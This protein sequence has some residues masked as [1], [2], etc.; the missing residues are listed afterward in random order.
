MALKLPTRIQP[1]PR[2]YNLNNCM[3][4]LHTLT[5]VTL[6]STK[7]E[8]RPLNKCPNKTPIFH[9]K[10][11]FKEKILKTNIH[12]RR[13]AKAT[14]FCFRNLRVHAL[15]RDRKAVSKPIVRSRQERKSDQRKAK[16]M[17]LGANSRLCSHCSSDCGASGRS[18]DEFKVSPK[19]SLCRRKK[20]FIA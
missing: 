3:E 20:M 13:A 17:E 2:P 16:R 12:R 11:S 19:W 1:I 18:A 5:V 4:F 7:K 9:S 8:K 10:K 15:S 6:S 14:R